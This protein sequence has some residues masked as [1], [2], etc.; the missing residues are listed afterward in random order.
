MELAK[1]QILPLKKTQHYSKKKQ[2]NTFYFVVNIY[3]GVNKYW[4]HI[5]NL[6]HIFLEEM[7]N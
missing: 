3:D 4:Y 1:A 7:L 5:S 2:K 6:I